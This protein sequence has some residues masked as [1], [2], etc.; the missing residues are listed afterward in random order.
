MRELRYSYD[1]KHGK[2]TACPQC[3]KP[4]RFTMWYDNVSGKFLPDRFGVCDRENSCGYSCS[5]YDAD[6]REWRR[7]WEKDNTDAAAL[8]SF[9]A[10]KHE[11]PAPPS[12]MPLEWLDTSARGDNTLATWMK[13]FIPANLVDAAMQLYHVGTAKDKSP[14]FWLIDGMNGVRTGKIITYD[15]T[16]HRIKEKRP[17]WVHEYVCDK[18]YNAVNVPFGSHLDPFLGSKPVGI[19]ESEKT[20]ILMSI[21]MPE[22]TWLAVGGSTQLNRMRSMIPLKAVL[23]ADDDEAGR[24]WYEWGEKNGHR[25]MRWEDHV[26]SQFR[27]AQWDIAD[28]CLFLGH[29]PADLNYHGMSREVGSS[30]Y[31]SSYSSRCSSPPIY[32]GGEEELQ[33]EDLD[34]AADNAAYSYLCSLN[35]EFKEFCNILNISPNS[36]KLKTS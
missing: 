21:Y 4:K 22:W 26:P 1:H 7:Q 2:K 33:K 24:A 12:L 9:K 19:V 35:P 10:K 16:G 23:W 31:S 27:S 11:A 17:R 13:T 5:P 30:S 6:N 36:W 32:R 8:V 18:N 25:V 20:A 14:V 15:T 3:G 28:L 34:V 29:A